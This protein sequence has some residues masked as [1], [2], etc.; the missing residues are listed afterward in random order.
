MNMHQLRLFC[1]VVERG[2][3]SAASQALYISQPAL[4]T[5][6]KR[7]ERAVGAT[8][9]QRG[10]TGAV[11]TEAGQLLYETAR[12]LF[13]QEN[14]FQRRLMEIRTGTLGTISVGVSHTGVLYALKEAVRDF[15][16]AYPRVTMDLHVDSADRLF[17][18]LLAGTLDLAVEWEPVQRPGLRVEPL[19]P[20]EFFLVAAPDHPLCRYDVVPRAAFLDTPYLA[21]QYGPGLPGTVELSLQRMQLLPRATT[22]V[23]SIDVIKQMIEAGLGVSVLSTVAV[24]RELRW[25]ELRRLQLEGF[26]LRRLTVLVY[27][28]RQLQRPLINRFSDFLRTHAAFTDTV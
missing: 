12:A 21:L 2:S 13:E 26:R 7:L 23:L 5:Q 15:L 18:R 1:T 24:R 27:G 20:Q 17:D 11:P 3:I 19:Q 28:Q 16:R 4:S 25:G 6:L 9:L 14:T 22:R 10:P 8:L